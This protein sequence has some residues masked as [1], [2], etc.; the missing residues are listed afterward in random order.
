M[1]LPG[2]LNPH[3]PK[4]TQDSYLDAIFQQSDDQTINQSIKQLTNQL[5]NQ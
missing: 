2:S 1:L 4:Q 5:I 3:P